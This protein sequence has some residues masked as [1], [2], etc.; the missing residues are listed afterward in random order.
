MSDCN[1]N[2]FKK[3]LE[4]DKTKSD[5]SECHL[6]KSIKKRNE[7]AVES[8]VAQIE[9]LGAKLTTDQKEE[10][11]AQMFNLCRYAYED[12]LDKARSELLDLKHEWVAENQAFSCNDYRCLCGRPL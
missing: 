11:M 8:I 7:Y 9:Q 5:R 4:K 6:K 1:Q 3:W 12:A 2:N 10:L